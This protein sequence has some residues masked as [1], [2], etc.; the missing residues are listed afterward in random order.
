LS[1]RRRKR[2]EEI[3]GWLKPVGL[4]R[5]VKFRG[6]RRVDWMF[7]FSTAVYNLVRIRN[8]EAAARA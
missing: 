5:K 6:L 2:V 8:L 4:M 7:R 1:Q 3:F